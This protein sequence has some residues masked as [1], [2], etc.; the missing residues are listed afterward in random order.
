MANN[1]GITR[2][3]KPEVDVQEQEG[4]D[5]K[6]NSCPTSVTKSGN[7]CL[8]AGSNNG[9]W[10]CDIAVTAFTVI[11]GN[12]IECHCESHRW[13]MVFLSIQPTPCPCLQS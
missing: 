3:V 4:V 5:G 6:W 10:S 13:W 7:I 11:A 1:V 12:A 8:N 2:A 9:I